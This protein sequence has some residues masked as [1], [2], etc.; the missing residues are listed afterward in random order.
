MVLT[1]NRKRVEV[2][3]EKLQE[4]LRTE[5]LEIGDRLPSERE[6]ANRFGVSRNS[7]REAL[8]T[9]EW[10]G[11]IAIRHGGGS[12]LKETNQ[13]IGEVLSVKLEGQ[14]SHLVFEMLEVR[15]ALEV[16]ATSL[17]AKR[18]NA[19]DLEQIQLS[20]KEMAVPVT[21]VEAGVQA[22][23]HFHLHIVR[24]SHNSILI[25]LMTTLMKEME[26][27]IRATRKNRFQELERYEETF[28]EHKH[29]Y[30]AIASGDSVLAKSLMEKHISG[31]RRE[32]SESLL[33]WPVKV[34]E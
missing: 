31:V 29:L 33:Q 24:A 5:G 19:R 12:F 8:K 25:H 9:L 10:E 15:R 14:E 22:D 27:T 20:L 6:L 34:R 4:M 23:L 17:A 13:S 26:T 30:L 2:V 32:L 28:E 16:E 7:V 3:L 11:I 21:E 1:E 18:A